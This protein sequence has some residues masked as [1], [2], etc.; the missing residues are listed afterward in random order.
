MDGNSRTIAGYGI[1]LILV[2]LP[3][4]C[5]GIGNHGLWTAD[6]PRV[7][8][9]GREM[10]LTGN[11]VVPTLNQKPFLEEPP[12]YYASVAAVF[13]VFGRVSDRVAR[14]PSVIY[15]LAGCLALFFLGAFLFGPRVGFLS[16]LVL[17]TGFE[18]FRVAHWLLVDSAL[19]CFVVTA[20][21]FFII[22][23]L[24]EAKGKKSLFYVL[25]YVACTGAF[26]TKGFIGMAVPG[27][28]ILAFLIVERNPKELLRMHLWLGIVIFLVLSLPWF[29]GLREQGGAEYL[30]VFF[31]KNHL[32][33]FLP[34]G[35]SGHHQP[36]Y[37]YLL[38][39]PEGFLPWS[40]LLVPVLF[41]SFRRSPGLPS[42]ER[43]G[44]AYLKCWFLMGII[45]LSAASTKRILY[46]M[47][48]F[49]PFSLLT[50]RYMDS[51]LLPRVITK[52]EKV[53]LH[54]FACLPL[55]LGLG[56][57]PA[58][59]GASA[60]YPSIASGPLF[61]A[62][63]AGSVLFFGLSLASL[64]Y[65]WKKKMDRFWLFGGGAF[66][67][68]LIF[69]LL[70]V[71]PVLDQF[72]SFV[73]FTDHVKS[74]VAADQEIYAYKPDETLRAVV[75]FYADR[76]MKETE[77]REF[78]AARAGKGDRIFVAIRDK[79][80]ELEEELL[81][82]GLFSVVARQGAREDRSIVLL[83]NRGR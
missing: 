40:L 4:F 79:R 50:A 69:S 5:L 6:E 25:F 36:F 52:L 39:F 20:M 53:F 68:V 8:E 29:F 7:A 80:G 41:F 27:L 51:T 48:I 75:P 9:I 35:S 59:I 78:L 70:A 74:I 43:S 32:Q 57:V 64:V 76:Y 26:F 15:S 46:L 3:L 16:S 11:V 33:R 23:Y 65:L 19:A 12:L 83:S 56:A 31:I 18:Y 73:P 55:V 10:A 45:F 58:Y 47:P 42:V 34:G 13:R 72:K 49:A 54:A 28:A 63:I 2:L 66:Y 62:V 71:I 81:S 21:T 60:K 38:G 82:T 22:G 14:I 44:I 67:A 17:A 24:S 1:A 77:S 61:S 30:R 37:Y